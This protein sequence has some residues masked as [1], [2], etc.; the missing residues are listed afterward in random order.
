MLFGSRDGFALTFDVERDP[1]LLCVDVFLGGLHLNT[2]DNAFYPP[3]LVKK[4][5][6]ELT[7]FDTPASPPPGFTS[8]AESLRAAE[9][10]RYEAAGAGAELAR[11][12]FLAW[13]ECTDDVSAF[14]FP[15]GDLVHLAC[16]VRDGGGPA[17]GTE[18]R[19]APTVATVS[20]TEL[21]DTLGQGL[22]A[23]ERAW[24]AR[25]TAASTPPSARA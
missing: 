8:P 14:A 5:R 18:P 3:L 17:W 10:G 16:R 13:G 24:S 11:Y 4:L 9:A 23:A 22:I 15:D 25:L 6:D 7:R 20:R 2:W 21:L 12:A 1:V 19:R